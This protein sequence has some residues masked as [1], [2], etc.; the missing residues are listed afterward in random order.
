MSRRDSPNWR[1]VFFFD[2][3]LSFVPTPQT[4]TQADANIKSWC[5]RWWLWAIIIRDLQV[6]T[7]YHEARQP[8][9]IAQARRN[10]HSTAREKAVLPEEVAWVLRISRV[11]VRQETRPRTLVL[12]PRTLQCGVWGKR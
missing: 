4:G 12:V 5:A 2:Q 6:F 8:L 3:R 11:R 10:A 7:I 9:L 1:R